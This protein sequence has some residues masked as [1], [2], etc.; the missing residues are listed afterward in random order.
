M[1]IVQSLGKTVFL[2]YE[3][4][5]HIKVWCNKFVKIAGSHGKIIK[6]DKR[7][8]KEN[9][10]R[11]RRNDH[12]WKMKRKMTKKPRKVKRSERKTF[13]KMTKMTQR[14]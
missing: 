10:D 9:K 11:E 5:V 8:H 6:Q 2:S 3:N 12:K 14:Q 1:Y 13:R 4:N 7:N